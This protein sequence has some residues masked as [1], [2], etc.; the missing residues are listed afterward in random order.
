MNN[1]IVGTRIT[2]GAIIGGFV[3]T[4]VWLYE[5][6]H[7]GVLIPAPVVVGL[8]TSITGLVQILIVNKWGVTTNK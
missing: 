6:T 4:S 2:F 1:I 3:A 7:P 8:T 5:F